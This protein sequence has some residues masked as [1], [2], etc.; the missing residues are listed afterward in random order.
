MRLKV[1]I[2]D[3]EEEIKIKDD[4]RRYFI[5]FVKMSFEDN[6]DKIYS[7]KIVKPFT[8]SV[9]LGK[10]FKKEKEEMIISPPVNLI[11]STGD[12]E[13]FTQFFNGVMKMKEENK[14]IKIGGGKI[15]RI[16]NLFLMKPAEITS[17]SAIF[18]TV[19]TCI[20]TNPD[21]DAKNFKRWFITPK[22]NL[23]EF[24]RIFEKRMNQKYE[25]IKGR[26]ISAKIRLIPLGDEE[27]QRLV[28]KGVI[29]GSFN[30]ES[31]KEVY[32]KHYGGFM[33]GF[34][35]V[36][37]LEGNPEMLQFVY[38]YGLGVRTGQGFGLIDILQK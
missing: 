24:N 12:F 34:K 18:K 33:R 26:K 22:D 27:R 19:E 10:N 29:P 28:R 21:E 36:F 11:F 3:E 15:L 30:H 32:V 23:D 20:L 16:K 1:V 4:Y 13:I 5:S 37:Y 2:G 31:I 8:F 7:K 14:G 25:I 17:S 6:F 9:F 35:G 38:D